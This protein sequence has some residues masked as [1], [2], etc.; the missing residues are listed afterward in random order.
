[1]ESDEQAT[2]ANASWLTRD[3]V[4]QLT[5][6]RAGGRPLGVSCTLARAGPGATRQPYP[7]RR[8]IRSKDRLD[9]V[10]GLLERLDHGVGGG[11]A[12]VQHHFE[13]LE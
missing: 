1:M 12:T 9:N 13:R 11:P 7:G 4:H 10:S 6:R 8:V 3:S 2:A 5:P